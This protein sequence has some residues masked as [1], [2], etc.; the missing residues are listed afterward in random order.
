MVETINRCDRF[1]LVVWW[2]PIPRLGTS[3]FP[4]N[5]EL[6][7]WG[8]FGCFSRLP[9]LSTY[10][11]ARLPPNSWLSACHLSVDLPPSPTINVYSIVV[12]STSFFTPPLS[13]STTFYSTPCYSTDPTQPPVTQLP[14]TQLMLCS[15]HHTPRHNPCYR[16]TMSHSKLFSPLTPIITPTSIGPLS[17]VFT[18]WDALW[19]LLAY[20]TTW[21]GLSSTP[22]P[23][24]SW[25]PDQISRF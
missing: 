22:P 10:S 8:P 13:Y 25:G 18:E 9:L 11:R 1:R 21:S 5:K 6:D 12:L 24:N 3:D 7:S 15:L 23:G 4:H 16:P 17:G 2:S 20:A 14:V 19:I